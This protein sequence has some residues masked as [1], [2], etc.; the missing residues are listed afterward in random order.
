MAHIRVGLLVLCALAIGVY[1]QFS[2][3]Y[4]WSVGTDASTS[5]C[6]ETFADANATGIFTYTPGVPQS[7]GP[8]QYAKDIQIG[9]TVADSPG[10]AVDWSVWLN[11][12]GA[13]YSDGQ[14]ATPLPLWRYSIVIFAS[15]LT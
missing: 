11:T 3:D 4:T 8:Y 5:I 7:S 10:D 1:G 2:T 9:A 14:F 6:N 12:N 13:N 15:R